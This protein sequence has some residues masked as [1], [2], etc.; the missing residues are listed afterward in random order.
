MYANTSS[1][2][3]LQIT[4]DQIKDFRKELEA[5]SDRFLLEGPGAVGG[6]LDKGEKWVM[7]ILRFLEDKLNRMS[8]FMVAFDIHIISVCHTISNVW[9]SGMSES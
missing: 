1:N 3:L 8:A 7:H 9:S 5:F 2:L 6:D 4:Q